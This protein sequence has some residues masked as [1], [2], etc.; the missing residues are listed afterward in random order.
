M[1]FL[2]FFSFLLV[3][4]FSSS[5]TFAKKSQLRLNIKKE[6]IDLVARKI[7]FEIN[8]PAD[9]AEI[10][11]YSLE[12]KLLAERVKLFEGAP[13]G[14]RLFID[15]P[16][17]LKD[18]EN[19]RIELKVTDVNDFWI[20]WEIL[21]FYLEIP[22]E[23]VVFE[24]GKWD[25][26]DSQKPKLDSALKQ[27]IDSVKKYGKNVEC[28]VYIAG[29]TDTVGSLTDNRLLSQKRARSIGTYFVKNGLKKVPIFIRGFGEESLAVKTDDNVSEE[30]NRRAIYIV[31]T[32]PPNLSGPGSWQSIQ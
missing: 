1:K 27:L 12:G 16:S 18:D 20:A 31:S 24:S 13:A 28:Q 29:H 17:L 30:K 3:F 6:D 5:L 8:R 32:L 25:I 23:E 22:H 4:S 9:N 10:K 14:T 21:R 11:V 19:F 7:F 15:W 2:F 26:R